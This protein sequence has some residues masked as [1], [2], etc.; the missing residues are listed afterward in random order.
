MVATLHAISRGRDVGT[1]YGDL[2]MLFGRAAAEA[3][4]DH[5]VEAGGEPG[6]SLRFWKLFHVALGELD[7]WLPG[8]HALG[9]TEITLEGLTTTVRGI[10]QR[11]LG[12]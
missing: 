11:V 4:V 6:E 12:N 3:F 10:G 1:C 8:L 5:Y 9:R 7:Q 2:S